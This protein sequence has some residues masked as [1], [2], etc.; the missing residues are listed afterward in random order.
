MSALRY[1]EGP[2]VG[3]VALLES[4]KNE[5]W[6]CHAEEA[7]EQAA[8]LMEGEAYVLAWLQRFHAGAAMPGDLAVVVGF[9]T[10]EMLKGACRILEQ[11]IGGQP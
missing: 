11:A 6:N 2:T 5:T 4:R 10:G 1:D 8:L 7:T 3:A 9:L